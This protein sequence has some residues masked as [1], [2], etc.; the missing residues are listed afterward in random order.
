MKKEG[1]DS[2]RRLKR[3]FHLHKVLRTS[4]RGWSASALCDACQEAHPGVDERTIGSDLKFMREHLHA[5]LPERTNKHHGYYYKT[6]YSLFEGLD[7][8]YLGSLNEALALLRQLS[9]SKEFIGLED[10]LLRLEQRVSVTS[11]EKNAVIQ[12]DT[13][14]LV[15][16]Q[17]LI[18]LYRAAQKQ[19]FLRVTYQTYQGNASMVRHVFPLLLKEY[20]NRWV[21]VVWE[22]DRPVPQNLPLDRIVS[23]HETAESFVHLKL[24]DSHT[25]FQHSLG[26]TKTGAEPQNVVLHFT[27]KRGKYVE[28]KKMHPYQEM[29][30]LPSGELEV[31][32]VVELNQEL[33]A[34]ILEFGSDVRVMA[35]PELRERIKVTL[36]TASERYE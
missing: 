20:N 7:D 5:P 6:P 35:P 12:F 31:R 30:W 21:L 32:L 18:G 25:Y 29:T 1:A 8:S 36:R 28:T 14:E 27:D 26:T 24:F 19:A 34:R 33:E 3:I 10:L 11:A 2:G 9:K 16:R 13:A 15:G 4:R 22:N 23:F 17:H